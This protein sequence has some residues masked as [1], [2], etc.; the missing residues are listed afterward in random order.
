MFCFVFP[1]AGVTGSC[2][3]PNLNVG[4]QSQV[5]GRRVHSIPEQ[6]RRAFTNDLFLIVSL[7][8]SSGFVNH[9]I[10]H[11][12]KRQRQRKV[13]GHI[14][15]ALNED[16]SLTVCTSSMSV[17]VR[18]CVCTCM[19]ECVHVRVLAFALFTPLYPAFC[20]Q[21]PGIEGAHFSLLPIT[22]VVL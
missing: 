1:G 6:D 3:M 18:V 20:L 19:C 16:S 11:T 15:L 13:N 12:A 9:E 14:D 4:N 7:K 21:S 2:E 8:A 17:C 22:T 10:K 5:L